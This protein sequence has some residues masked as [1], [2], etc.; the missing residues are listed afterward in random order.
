MPHEYSPSSNR[1]TAPVSALEKT[2]RKHTEDLGYQVKKLPALDGDT[3]KSSMSSDKFHDEDAAM[4]GL[5]QLLS[6]A[7]HVVIGLWH[8]TK[9]TLPG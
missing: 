7:N 1:S 2:L 6:P 3:W 4:S 9:S 8:R 5:S